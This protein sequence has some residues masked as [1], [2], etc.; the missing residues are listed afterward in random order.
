MNSLI[1]LFILFTTS[2]SYALVDIQGS[3]ETLSQK[4]HQLE[5]TYKEFQKSQRDHQLKIDSLINRKLEL[6]QQLSRENL[7]RLQI[8]EKRKLI[9]SKDSSVLGREDEEYRRAQ[10]ALI[11]KIEDH[12]NKSLPMRK[13]EKLNRLKVIQENLAGAKTKAQLNESALKLWDLCQQELKL[14]NRI[15]FEI[16]PVSI[17]GEYQTVESL[18]F[19]SLFTLLKTSEGKIG[20]LRY[21]QAEVS[22]YSDEASKKSAEAI[23]DSY[24]QKTAN[25]YVVLP[26]GV[27]K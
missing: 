12:L 13:E 9:F 5:V 16:L 18:R 2:I 25:G 21:N 20:L 10:Q 1:T 4:R 7:R 19:G 15:G 22:F 17:S 3:M 27:L 23:L 24:R 6:E 8:S 26:D 11:V 14:V